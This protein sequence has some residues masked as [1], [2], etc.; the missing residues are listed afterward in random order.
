MKLECLCNYRPSLGQACFKT[1]LQD[2]KLTNVEVPN[3]PVI[4]TFK[5]KD[6]VALI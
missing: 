4:L 3:F 1:T 2:G 5:D 6:V